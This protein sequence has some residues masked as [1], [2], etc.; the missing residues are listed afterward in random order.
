MPDAELQHLASPA[1]KGIGGGI[2]VQ[3][4]MHLKNL[5]NGVPE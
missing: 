3:K 2:V 4:G 1:L 5:V